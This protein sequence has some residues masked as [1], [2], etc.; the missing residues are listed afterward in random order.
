MPAQAG[1]QA[2]AVPEAS[3]LL[4]GPG[5]GHGRRTAS[6][7]T[8]GGKTARRGEGEGEKM[9]EEAQGEAMLTLVA[10]VLA[11]E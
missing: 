4:A 10:L 2:G 3:G 7:A 5:R 6:T 1:R 11:A 8:A 9:R